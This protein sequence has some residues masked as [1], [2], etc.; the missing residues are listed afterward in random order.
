MAYAVIRTGGKQ[1]RVAEGDVVR[2]ATLAGAPGDKVTFNEV[3]ALGGDTPRLGQPLVSGAAVEGE[4][5]E[6]GRG[7]K[8][9]VFKFRRRKRSRRKAGHRQ[10]FTAVRITGVKG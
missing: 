1:Y 4:I 3:L 2:V 10:A 9:V 8:L 7:E 6:H 5:V